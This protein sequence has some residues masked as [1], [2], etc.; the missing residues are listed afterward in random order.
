MSPADIIILVIVSI[1]VATLTV[2]MTRRNKEEPCQNCQKRKRIRKA[3]KKYQK[4][5]KY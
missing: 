5:K 2:K 4:G 3:I 1:I